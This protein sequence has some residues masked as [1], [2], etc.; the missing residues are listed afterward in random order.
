MNG[1]I[2][3]CFEPNFVS[4]LILPSSGKRP[5]TLSPQ[6]T[7]SKAFPRSFSNAISPQPPVNELISRTWV[8]NIHIRNLTRKHELLDIVMKSLL[9]PNQMRQFIDSSSPSKISPTV[10]VSSFRISRHILHIPF[11]GFVA[12][13]TFL[14]MDCSIW[15]SG[16]TTTK[17]TTTPTFVIRTFC[18]QPELPDFVTINHFGGENITFEV[19]TW[20]SNQWLIIPHC[21]NIE[22]FVLLFVPTLGIAFL[23]FRKSKR[24]DICSVSGNCASN[25]KSE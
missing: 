8:E 12:A 7:R 19:L 20:R 24:R 9:F 23:L 16:T 6:I 13:L 15:K 11:H 14:R 2:F 4:H 22:F 25:S 21:D 17:T 10:H 18:G 1:V 3:I 5:L